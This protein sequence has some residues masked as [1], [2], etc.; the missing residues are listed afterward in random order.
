MRVVK[1][2]LYSA[3]TVELSVH[4]SSHTRIFL[5]DSQHFVASFASCVQNCTSAL[6]L[7]RSWRAFPPANSALAHTQYRRESACVYAVSNSVA[8]NVGSVRSPFGHLLNHNARSF[9][10]LSIGVQKRRS[11]GQR[12]EMCTYMHDETDGATKCKRES[13]SKIF[14]CLY[15]YRSC[16]MRCRICHVRVV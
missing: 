5:S 4:M 15:S 16:E 8:K 11:G 6:T 13:N 3:C 7:C 14:D 2:R 9:N 1:L 12:G 10:A